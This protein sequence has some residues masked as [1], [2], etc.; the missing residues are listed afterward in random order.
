LGREAIRGKGGELEKRVTIRGSF[1]EAHGAPS[2]EKVWFT[3][4]S[5]DIFWAD[6][7]QLWRAVEAT[8]VASSQLLFMA[9]QRV[10]VCCYFGDDRSID[11]RGRVPWNGH[12]FCRVSGST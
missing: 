10:Q 5:L 2:L 9:T 1:G 8:R 7:Q 3:T 6:E 4:T 11:L 12:Q